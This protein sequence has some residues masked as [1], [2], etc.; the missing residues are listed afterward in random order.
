M[1]FVTENL[2]Y[3]IAGYI[4]R[5][6]LKT[7]DCDLYV[8]SLLVLKQMSHH[9]YFTSSYD[10]LVEIKKSSGLIQSSHFVYKIITTAK[11]ILHLTV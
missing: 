8:E 7:A 10:S 2:L 5:S 1:T 3:S 11:R 4:L 9:Q 6:I